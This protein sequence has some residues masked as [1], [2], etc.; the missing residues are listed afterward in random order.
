[1]SN[2]NRGK[3]KNKNY[4]GIFPIKNFPKHSFPSQDEPS[5]VPNEGNCKLASCARARPTVPIKIKNTEGRKG[6]AKG[7]KL[8]Q[9]LEIKEQQ[10]AQDKGT[11]EHRG[12]GE[13]WVCG[14]GNRAG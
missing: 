7:L 13:E 2:L 9:Y 11:Q 4:K 1:M 10:Q 3:T 14:L 5:S 8:T 6:K 12:A